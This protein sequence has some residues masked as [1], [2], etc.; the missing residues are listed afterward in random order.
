MH[1]TITLSSTA[2]PD[3][4]FALVDDL[5]DYPRWLDLVVSAVPLA[6]VDSDPGPAWIVDLRARLGP[7]AR[8]KRL[9]MVRTVHDAG[10]VTFVR[11]END[12]RTHAA[13]ILDVGVIAGGGGSE[14]TMDLRYEGRLGGPLLERLL[15][16][17]VERAT[18]RL[19]ALA[20]A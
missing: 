17:E 18:P 13:W 9:R 14:L 16:E 3:V 6:S 20:E 10:R 8:H 15:A 19:R 1:S 11:R 2:A 7:L 5:S 4:L 12:G